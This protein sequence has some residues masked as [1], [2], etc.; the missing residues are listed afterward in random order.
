MYQN[1]FQQTEINIGPTHRTLL[2]AKKYGLMKTIHQVVETGQ[3][4]IDLKM[5]IKGKIKNYERIRWEATTI[6]YG[7]MNVYREVMGRNE[8]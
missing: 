7:N 5:Y 4:Q 1:I 8:V 3:I 2:A 6:L